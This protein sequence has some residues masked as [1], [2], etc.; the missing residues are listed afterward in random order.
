MS[1]PGEASCSTE[2]RLVVFVVK[3]K[4]KDVFRDLTDFL[5][6]ERPI[7][8]QFLIFQHGFVDEIVSICLFLH[9]FDVSESGV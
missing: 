5:E 8:I 9:S 6:F 2:V 1:Y 4:K 7:V 3:G